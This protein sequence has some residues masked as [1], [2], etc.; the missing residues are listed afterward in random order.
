MTDKPR[1]PNALGMV[2]AAEIC[3]ALKPV[4]KKLVVAGS[5]RRRKPTIGDVEILYVGEF[6][7]R[8]H[9][10]DMFASINVN[11]ADEA[12]A[13]LESSGVL[14]RRKNVN[15]STMYG[16][17]NKL[18]RHVASGI[19][20]DLFSVPQERCPCGI[21]PH[22][23]KGTKETT[24]T[25]PHSIQTELR[26]VR[27]V[28]RKQECKSVLQEMQ[29]PTSMGRAEGQKESED[30]RVLHLRELPKEISGME[31]LEGKKTLLPGV[32]E[33]SDGTS[34][35]GKG[36]HESRVRD[37]AQAGLQDGLRSGEIPRDKECQ[38][39]L[40]DGT[41]AGDGET[42]REKIASSGNR[43]SQEW[44]QG[45][46]PD[47][48]FTSH[49]SQDTHGKGGLPALSEGI[50]DKV[51]CPICHG[52]GWHAPNWFVSLVIRTGSKEMN[53]K[54]TD[55]AIKLGRT[56]N[57]YGSGVTLEDGRVMPATS[58]EDVFFLCQVPYVPPECR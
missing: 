41:Q 13:K 35:A 38:K 17:K 29:R 37:V 9:P 28:L 40:R 7:T 6:E 44:H 23:S 33:R 42:S 24:D 18:M 47:K 11:L 48:E 39:I 58:E 19:P 53:L 43:S 20:V 57:A 31:L 4:C 12:I 45:R 46:Q 52:T 21:V 49:A 26:R 10:E 3:A 54:L 55:G 8:Q 27:Q 15:G 34:A 56:L 51:M 36:G 14:E 16:P 25:E 5:L 30:V 1:F 22:E 2:V 50:P 32:R